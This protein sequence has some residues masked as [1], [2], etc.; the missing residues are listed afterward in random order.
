MS[1][2]AEERAGTRLSTARSPGAPVLAVLVLVVAGLVLLVQALHLRGLL[3]VTSPL[4]AGFAKALVLFYGVAVAALTAAAAFLPVRRLAVPVVAA[5]GLATLTLLATLTVGGEAWSFLAAALV[6]CACWLAGR[7][8]L[9]ALRVPALA[10]QA[11]VAWLA[12][13]AV[14][15]L[16]LLFCGRA[17]MLRW[18]TLGAPVLALGAAGA[19]M[20]ARAAAAGPATAAWQRIRSDRLSAGCASV[21]LLL[22]GLACVWTASPDLMYDAVYG[23]AWLPAEWA[24]TGAIEPLRAHPVLN[25]A[26]FAQLLA[27][28]GHLV[29]A[30][31]IGQYMQW[32]SAGAVVATVWWATRSSGWA[33]LCA[34]AVA[35]TPQLFWQ[36]STAFDDALLTLAVLGLGVAV[37]VTLQRSEGPP[38]REG[39]ALGLLAGAC[40]DYKLHLAV[41]SLA[42]MLGWLFMRGTDRPRALVGLALGGMAAAAPAFALRWI[43]V[44][45]P[46]LPAYN[47]IFKSSY[48][49][50][51]NE[52]LNFPFFQ[53]G[54]PLE[55]IVK[56]VTEPSL[57]NEAAPVGAMGF[58]VVAILVLIVAGWRG[59]WSVPGLPAVWF[60]VLIATVAWYFQFRYLRYLLPSG[61]LAVVA[62]GLAL[63]GRVRTRR[64]E[65]VALGAVALSAVMFWP[66]TVAL[67]WNVP[68]RDIPLAVALGSRADHDY[69][70]ASMIELDALD[71]YDRLAPPGALALG[72]PH[73]RLWLTEGRDLSPVWEVTSRL[74]IDGPMPTGA[75][76]YSGVRALG[77]DWMIVGEGG[78][79]LSVP[80]SASLLERHGEVVWADRG[81]TVYRLVDSAAT[82]TPLES[83][84]D[85]LAGVEGCWQG[86]LDDRPGLRYEESPAGI[87]RTVPL[88]P[89]A[90]L[91]VD[92]RADGGAAPLVVT[93]DFDGPDPSR[94]H[95]FTQLTPGSTRPAAG[96][97]PPGARNATVSLRPAPG[98]EVESAELRRLGSCAS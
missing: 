57:L 85:R 95:T 42:L 39:L 25:A 96:T 82:G 81:W 38:F 18:W 26:G 90:T 65:L 62:I 88:C 46:V 21:G 30:E 1:A 67:F 14:L 83:C 68:G 91:A 37:M 98:M 22:L 24:R 76:L 43:D 66:S 11:P 12:G 44:G 77:I 59:S 92:V 33:P 56:S 36:T 74:E 45:N 97:A 7:L 16:V 2:V 63:P 78:G 58:L 47:N 70:R 60:A 28:P 27:L 54:N 75:R 72:D 17:G 6:M 94:G 52:T 40:V 64:A 9:T 31:G 20:L 71:A 55:V 10:A 34:I 49:P 41:L 50:P 61:A 5:A 93:V 84:D 29:G 79:A 51:V 35:I 15:G 89:G 48:W 8:L 32:I 53:D 4:T 23:K 19:V 86:T 69:E 87:S 3:D 73:Q 80:W 13:S